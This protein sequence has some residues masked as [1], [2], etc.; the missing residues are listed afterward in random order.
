MSGSFTYVSYGVVST[1][2]LRFSFAEKAMCT[3]DF[4][5]NGPLNGMV[6]EINIYSRELIA[7]DVYA[8][9]SF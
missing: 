2:T 4:I 1:I 6:N 3:A 5:M 8:L 7:C 9:V